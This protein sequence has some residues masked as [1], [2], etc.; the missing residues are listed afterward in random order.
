MLDC[1]CVV[2]FVVV[3]IW[4]CDGKIAVGGSKGT[5]LQNVPLYYICNKYCFNSIYF[6]WIY[7]FR[8]GFKVQGPDFLFLVLLKCK[9]EYL[10][11]CTDPGCSQLIS[12]IGVCNALNIAGDKCNCSSV[13]GLK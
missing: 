1:L 13:S 2:K 9:C 7:L 10:L 5:L 12:Y 4:V 8:L 3:Y 6:Y 11:E